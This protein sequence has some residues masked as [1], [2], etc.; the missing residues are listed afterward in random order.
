MRD[1]SWRMLPTSTFMSHR[2]PSRDDEPPQSLEDFVE[3]QLPDQS[4]PVNQDSPEQVPLPDGSQPGNQGQ[5]DASTTSGRRLPV[6]LA[7]LGVVWWAVPLAKLARRWHRRHRGRPSGRVV[8]AWR[9]VIDAGLDLGRSVPVGATRETQAA[10]L[11]VASGVARVADDLVFGLELPSDAE[12]DEFWA[13]AL[14]ARRELIRSAGSVRRVRAFYS[15]TSLLA[16]IRA[17][18]SRPTPVWRRL[19]DQLRHRGRRPVIG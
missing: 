2:K 14:E 6:A 17:V 16:S 3:D 4:D 12:V 11:G 19:L 13:T 18:R 15:P 5:S 10:A 7:L 1:G 8:G 9:E